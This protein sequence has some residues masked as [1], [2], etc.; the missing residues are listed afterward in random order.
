MAA[1]DWRART[2]AEL[3]SASADAPLIAGP[4]VATRSGEKFYQELGKALGAFFFLVDLVIFS[5]NAA[6]VA[7]KIVRSEGPFPKNFDPMEP[8]PG[9]QGLFHA[10]LGTL[11]EPV[12]EMVLCRLVDN[13]TS[14]LSEV[15]REC[16]RARPEI[17]KSKETLTVE[18]LLQF[19]SLE[20]LQNWL[21]DRKVDELAYA[22]F[23]NLS[24][25]LEKRLGVADFNAIPARS[26]LVETLE[27]RNCIVHN[28]SRASA[29]YVRA[30]SERSE[31]TPGSP[32]K[33]DVDSLFLTARAT[34]DCVQFL[35]GKLSAKF[36]LPAREIP[37]PR[38]A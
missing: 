1:D 19:G 16:L 8:L 23:G 25:W 9:S 13:F 11:S 28:R 36:G 21:V 18:S 26:M 32:I 30:V 20:E 34:A 33:V 29:K 7:A 6:S 35:D 10:R 17:L 14:Y 15:I 2:L 24:E 22:G 12:Q 5:D 37:S 38:K 4:L 3:E 27:L 31:L